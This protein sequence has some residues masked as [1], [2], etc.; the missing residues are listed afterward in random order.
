MKRLFYLTN[1]TVA[2]LLVEE[3]AS[4][5]SKRHQQEWRMLYELGIGPR[6][7]GLVLLGMPAVFL[8]ESSWLAPSAQ[9]ADVADLR[10]HL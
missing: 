9:N 8:P 4:L 5:C 7:F 10:H 6:G 1:T 3:V 2:Q